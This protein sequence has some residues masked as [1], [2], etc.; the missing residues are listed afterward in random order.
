MEVVQQ[1]RDAGI[2]AFHGLGVYQARFTHA[3]QV[4]HGGE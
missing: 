1:G 4:G 2:L 3:A